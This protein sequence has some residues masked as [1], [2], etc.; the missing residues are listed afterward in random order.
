M[1][2]SINN[3]SESTGSQSTGSG[4]P[5]RGIAMILLAVAVMLFA[6]GVYSLTNSGDKATESAGQAETPV[7]AQATSAPASAAS[8]APASS[9]AT[10]A[11]ASS[12]PASET[13]DPAEASRQAAA[14]SAAA[15]NPKEVPV[16]ALNNSTVQGL[17]NR[18][19]GDLK[20][21]GWNLAEV[22]NF[23]NEILPESTVFYAPGNALEEQAANEIATSLG[24]KAAPRI[25]ALKS[26]PPGVIV[27]IAEDLNK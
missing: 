27:V 9:A 12:A 25:D 16:H 21:K 23:P 19:A 15:Q 1:F 8:A 7:A 4:L 20:N 17:A 18:V 14:Q 3:S 10:S 2:V 6:W 26:T 13:K 22:G 5:L 24:I 11:P